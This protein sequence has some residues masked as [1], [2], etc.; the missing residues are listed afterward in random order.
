MS[1]D[2]PRLGVRLGIVL[3]LLT[4]VFGVVVYLAQIDAERM[5]AVVQAELDR[6]NRERSA[7]LEAW[8]RRIA[9]EHA[10]ELAAPFL[11]NVS[12]LE[13]VEEGTPAHERLQRRMWQFVYGKDEQPRWEDAPVGPL[14]SVV[15]IGL[16]HR[17]G[18]RRRLERGQLGERDLT[19]TLSREAECNIALGSRS[20]PGSREERNTEQERLD[21]EQEGQR[22]TERQGAR[23]PFGL[24]SSRSRY[25]EVS[26]GYREPISR[27]TVRILTGN[28]NE[29]TGSW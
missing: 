13:G 21:D 11:W 29:P 4:V 5:A 15:I 18:G 24:R 28:R 8:H 26:L 20:R 17:I 22:P 25:F 16:D 3:A 2:V 7:A 12:T 1:A 27:N 10:R 19:A 23:N 14:E 9:E 6:Q